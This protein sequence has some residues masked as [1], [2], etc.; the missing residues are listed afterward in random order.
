MMSCE[1]RAVPAQRPARHFGAPQDL[2]RGAT[3]VLVARVAHLRGLD[4]PVHDA[5]AEEVVPLAQGPLSEA[6]ARVLAWFGAD[7]GE[8][9][10]LVTAVVDECEYLARQHLA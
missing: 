8:D 10:D 4:A 2:P 6:V 1:E 7:L 9:R 3:G 5:R